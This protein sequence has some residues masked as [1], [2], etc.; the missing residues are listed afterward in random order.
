MRE[1]P[2]LSVFRLWAAVA[3]ADGAVVEAEAQQYQSL[4]DYAGL[5]DAE[6]TTARGFLEH[7]IELDLGA[8]AV[9]PKAREN[10]YETAV[11][12]AAADHEYVLQ[13]LLV[14]SRL[15][16][17][18]NIDDQRAREIEASVGSA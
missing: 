12:M 15:Q 8:L 6:R 7:K 9:E 4:L 18:L 17:A 3:W 11:R 5:G 10:V 1:N 16:A 13:E 14:L 2:S